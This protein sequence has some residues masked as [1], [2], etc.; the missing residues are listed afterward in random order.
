MV[1]TRCLVLLVVDLLLVVEDT[2][3]YYVNIPERLNFYWLQQTEMLE[4]HIIS[5]I[6]KGN[7]GSVVQSTMG[8][9]RDKYSDLLADFH[10][11][12][13]TIW[14]VTLDLPRESL[15]RFLT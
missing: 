11:V 15:V 8:A 4:R 14:D 7:G 1:Y 10:C 6:E 3:C 13:K 2:T 5:V 9:M 12:G